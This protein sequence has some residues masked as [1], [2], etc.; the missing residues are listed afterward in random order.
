MQARGYKLQ[1]A[2]WHLGNSGPANLVFAI[3]YLLLIFAVWT[4]RS[5][6]PQ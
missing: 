5:F 3:C 2:G 4:G 1:A 6:F